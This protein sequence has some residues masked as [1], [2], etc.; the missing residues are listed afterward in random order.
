MKFF[1]KKPQRD[2]VDITPLID[3]VFTLLV[4]FML[5]G[6]MRAPDAFPVDAAKSKSR[7]YGDER[8]AVV[9]VAADGS[10]GLND[11]L[12]SKPELISALTMLLNEN[13][14]A[15]VQIKADADS[16]AASVIQLME[17]LREAGVGYI[18]LLTKG[19]GMEDAP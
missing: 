9:L 3:L 17:D 1:K 4:F 2:L 14:D 12:M 18:V 8:E 6:A 11:T 10:L 7:V 15:L 16:D 19:A 13:P 5:A